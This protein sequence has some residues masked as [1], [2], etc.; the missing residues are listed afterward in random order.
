MED[1]RKAYEINPELAEIFKEVGISE[2]FGVG[3]L[4]PSDWSEFGP[5]Q[6]TLSEF[7]DA[8]EIFQKEMVSILK[9]VIQGPMRSV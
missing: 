5:V 3:G 1:F 6:K 9:D 2:D 4:M 8:Y 7:K